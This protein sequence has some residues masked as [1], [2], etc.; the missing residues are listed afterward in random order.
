MR[1]H[2]A[3][4]LYSRRR[5]RGSG[6]GSK[7]RGGGANSSSIVV[8][9]TLHSTPLYYG[10]NQPW[11]VPTPAFGCVS[12]IHKYSFECATKRVCAP[13]CVCVGRSGECKKSTSPWPPPPLP[14]F[15]QLATF[16]QLVL[17]TFFFFFLLCACRDA[18]VSCLALAGRPFLSECLV[19]CPT[20]IGL[21]LLSHRQPSK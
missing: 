16:N 13:A 1:Q 9:D 18:C 5:E 3:P 4:L 7:K 21:W 11:G 14:P 20:S 19:S 8:H 15:D 10:K 12:F 17:S 2:S 6:Q